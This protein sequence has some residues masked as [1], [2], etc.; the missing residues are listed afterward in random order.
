MA[1]GIRWLDEE[2]AQQEGGGIRWLDDEPVQEEKPSFMSSIP[3]R[4][5]KS[6]PMGFASNIASRAQRGELLTPEE[7]S[8][9]RGFGMGAADPSVGIAQ[10][11]ANVAGVGGGMNEAIR[12]KEA[13][14]QAGRE[15]AGREGFDAM[16]MAGNVV[17]PATMLPVTGLARAAPAV[18]ALERIWQGAGV[19]G[20]IGLSMP[21]T[22]EGD[23]G[24][25][26]TAQALGGMAVG[27][28]IPAVTGLAGATYQGAKN[29]IGP[30][31][32][33][34]ASDIAASKIAREISG[35]DANQI[36]NMLRSGEIDETAAQAAV[37]SGRPEFAAL[38]EIMKGKLPKEFDQV[39]LAQDAARRAQLERLARGGSV[40]ESKMAQE[41]IK[42][43][44]EAGLGPVRETELGA[45]NAGRT[46]DTSAIY[47]RIGQITGDPK[48]AGNMVAEKSLGNVANLIREWETKGGGVIDAQALYGIRKNAIN[49]TV[50]DLLKG[51]DPKSASKVAASLE[52]KIRPLIDDAIENAGG[53]AWKSYLSQ[54]SKGLGQVDR[55]AVLDKARDLY[56]TSQKK[57][58]DLVK[59]DSP[60][61]IQKIMKGT[62]SVD[63][64]LNPQTVTKLDKIAGQLERD[65]E[66]S[67]QAAL[68]MKSAGK[69]Y[70]NIEDSYQGVPILSRPVVLFTNIVNR[71][72]GRGG[73]NIDKSLAELMLPQ[74]KGR[75]ADLMEQ[76]APNQRQMVMNELMRRGY[77][78]GAASEIGREQG[79]R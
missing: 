15:A 35:K 6:T 31:I 32:S 8:K 19:G 24:E 52:A 76:A 61:V 53:T 18:G 75:L 30:I 49:Q 22:G 37:R 43:R 63:D 25:A 39:A 16:R 62:Y 41:A 77:I 67:R 40:E 79:S 47:N 60:K 3:E 26:K 54:Y 21:V 33:K 57:F 34:Q 36:I 66:V 11:A 20:A 5:W 65:T 56:R 17:S 12:A 73:A 38:G 69:T 27:G 7:E 4:L 42:K 1:G 48:Y 72:E 44:L 71:L 74:N 58:I 10:Y 50:N 29:L 46:I 59:G 51:Q 9:V 68:G 55:I 70:R 28:L 14:Y 23:F 78:S 13:E 2:P 45:A 64:A